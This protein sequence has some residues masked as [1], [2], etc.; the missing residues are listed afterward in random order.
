[1]ESSKGFFRCSH[2]LTHLLQHKRPKQTPRNHGLSVK[3]ALE[4][5]FLGGW[6]RATN[7]YDDF[8]QWT[9]GILCYIMMPGKKTKKVAGCCCRW[10]NSWPFHPRSLEVTNNH[11]KGSLTLQK[12][13]IDTKNCHVLRELYTSSKPSFR[14][15][16]LVFRVVTIPRRWPADFKFVHGRRLLFFTFICG[17]ISW[18]MKKGPL[19]G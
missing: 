5:I 15:S 9:L 6:K 14:V 4:L 19:V 13:N 3:N 7:M 18:L 11:L 17:A 8:K 10:F 16:M 12:C 1:M 2:V